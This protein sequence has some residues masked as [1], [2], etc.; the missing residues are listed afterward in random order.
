MVD[1]VVIETGITYEKSAI[2]EH[3][4][5]NGNFCPSTR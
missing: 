3:L 2:N 5:T 1:P 4:I